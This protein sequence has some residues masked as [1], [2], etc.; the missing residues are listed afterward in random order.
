[1]TGYSAWNRFSIDMSCNQP[2][3]SQVL[4]DYAQTVE[5]E[6]AVA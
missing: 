2:F 4:S 3:L 5:T 6:I 1:M